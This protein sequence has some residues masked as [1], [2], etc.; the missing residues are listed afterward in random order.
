MSLESTPSVSAVS[1]ASTQTAKR[2]AGRRADG[3]AATESAFAQLLQGQQL[4]ADARATPQP[5]ATAD[6]RKNAAAGEDEDEPAATQEG[7]ESTSGPAARQPRK[8]QL[9]A[10]DLPAVPMTAQ[11]AVADTMGRLLSAQRAQAR[12]AA[13]GAER[14]RET[15]QAMG[16]ATEAD[17]ATA[18]AASPFADALARA[19]AREA[20]PPDEAAARPAAAVAT[21]A[22][23][24]PGAGA[25]A[26]L[27]SLAAPGDVPTGTAPVQVPDKAPVPDAYATLAPS[28]GSEAFPAAL[29]AQ[30]STW[31]SEGVEHAV[32][33]LNPRELGPIEVHIALRDGATRIELGS[34]VAST[35]DALNQALPQLAEALGDVGLALAGGQVSDQA[36]GQR[37]PDGGD[38][39]SQA[40]QAGAWLRGGSGAESA[41]SA[42]GPLPRPPVNPRALLDMYA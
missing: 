40:R 16:R 25:E 38:A 42:A 8:D 9:S 22:A 18:L 6:S 19:A 36:S 5:G 32:L 1:A 23:P 14:G 26:V 15:R 11:G 33:E 21:A 13:L 4:A 34:D 17:D 2:H 10:E 24:A 28:P 27:P 31:V 39:Q 7:E 37:S 30:L 29:G 12:Q 41:V 20:V 35:R 3:G